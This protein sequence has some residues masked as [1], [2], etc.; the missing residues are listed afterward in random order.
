MFRVSSTNKEFKQ[1]V[2]LLRDYCKE[3]HITLEI[4]IGDL[5]VTIA[6]TSNSYG[7][8][9]VVMGDDIYYNGIK[10]AHDLIDNAN[11]TICRKERLEMPPRNRNYFNYSDLSFAACSRIDRITLTPMHPE[12]KKVIFND[13]ATIVYWAD[14]S[15]TVVKC[16]DESFDK[17]K[18]LAM[19]IVK[20]FMGSNASKSNY[21][22][23]FK[24]FIGD[25]ND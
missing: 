21:N 4:D 16:H 3:N 20:K 19:A 10:I 7:I 18:G 8:R 14:G 22:D 2:D 24:K 9:R 13:P 1:F 11:R 15:K 25:N 12:I 6:M 17:E 23:I 5:Y